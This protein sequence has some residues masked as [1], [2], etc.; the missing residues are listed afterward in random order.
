MIGFK[1][2]RRVNI[3]IDLIACLVNSKEKI[4]LDNRPRERLSEL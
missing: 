3:P 2:E 1:N 4:Q